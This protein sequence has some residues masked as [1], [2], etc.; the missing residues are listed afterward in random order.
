[1]R[2]AP[3]ACLARRPRTGPDGYSGVLLKGVRFGRVYLKTRTMRRTTI[4]TTLTRFVTPAKAPAASQVSAPTSAR[5]FSPRNRAPSTLEPL[6]AVLLAGR[7]VSSAAVRAEGSG[8]AV[9][10]GDGP[11]AVARGA[12]DDRRLF[13]LS[14]ASVAPLKR[15]KPHSQ[16]RWGSW[17]PG[18]GSGVPHPYR[19]EVAQP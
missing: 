8:A 2:C 4:P 14:V 19:P 3:G 11:Q 5:P 12:V 16:G 7:D 17:D 18:E 13:G 6:G 1:M 9:A 10:M 15:E